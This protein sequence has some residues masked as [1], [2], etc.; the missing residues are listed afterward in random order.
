MGVRS[1]MGVPLK[2]GDGTVIGHLAVLDTRPLPDVPRLITVFELFA[3]RAAAE[4]RRLRVE[5]A[6]REREEKLARLVDGAMDAIIELDH[7]LRLTHVNAA[8]EKVFGRPAAELVGTGFLSLLVASER[9]RI[10]GSRPRARRPRRRPPARSGSR[11]ASARIRER[12]RVPGRGDHLAPS[13]GRARLPHGRAAG[14]QRA[15]TSPRN[16]SARSRTRSTSA[17][18]SKASSARVPACGTS[19]ARS[20]RSPR[21]MRAS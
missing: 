8:A 14:R 3:E 5:T 2:D 1:Y 9:E 16:A 10:L 13:P 21:R 19:F 15:A 4:L 17:K 20:T 18:G 7:D 6:V 12:R 11:A